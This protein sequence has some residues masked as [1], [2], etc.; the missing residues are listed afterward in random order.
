[1]GL[2]IPG[3]GVEVLLAAVRL[4]EVAPDPLDAGARCVDVSVLE[5]GEN[6]PTPEVDRLRLPADVLADRL[7]VSNGEDPAVF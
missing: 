7:L 5:S 2:G 3:D 6:R 1:V 4:G